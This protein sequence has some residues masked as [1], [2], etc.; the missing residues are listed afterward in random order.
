[1]GYSPL[2]S[3]TGGPSGLLIAISVFVLAYLY[4]NFC[5]LIGAWSTET[6]PI[7]GSSMDNSTPDDPIEHGSSC[8]ESALNDTDALPKIQYE[9]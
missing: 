6:L 9:T 5:I 2:P 1:M 4:I 3:R 8:C 7:G